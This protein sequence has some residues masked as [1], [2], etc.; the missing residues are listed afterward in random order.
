M[1]C[2][3]CIS[4]R[5][6]HIPC[7]TIPW[8]QTMI[9]Q[10]G[11]ISSCK[12]STVRLIRPWKLSA[13]SSCTISGILQP[14][15]LGF[16]PD[17]LRLHSSAQLQRLPP[18]SVTS[19]RTHLHLPSKNLSPS[20]FVCSFNHPRGCFKGLLPTHGMSHH[21]LRF[22]IAMLGL[23]FASFRVPPLLYTVATH[24]KI[25]TLRN[26]SGHVSTRRG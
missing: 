15:S 7:S 24:A 9:L 21:T 10:Q 22:R 23:F 14:P 3:C 18:R 11:D 26:R 13:E 2:G 5:S 25:G 4:Q 17:D 19:A 20:Y 16:V 6:T 8:D 12:L 1:A